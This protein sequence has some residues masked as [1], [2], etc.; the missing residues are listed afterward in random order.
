LESLLEPTIEQCFT[1]QPAAKI[2]GARHVVIPDAGH[3]TAL[4]NPD[5]FYEAIDRFLAGQSG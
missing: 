5:T 3:I 4:E 1:P 2:P